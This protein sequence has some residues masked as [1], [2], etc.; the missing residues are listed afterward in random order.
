[1]SRS[2]KQAEDVLERFVRDLDVGVVAFQI[3]H[4][5]QAAIEIRDLT[6]QIRQLR[7]AVG[8]RLA[9][10]LVKQTQQEQPI[11]TQEIAL[12]LFLPHAFEA[13]AKIIAVAVEEAALLDEVDEHHPVQH[14]RG[15]PFP[16]GEVLDAFDKAQEGVMLLLETVVESLGDLLYVEGRARPADHID[17]GGVCLFIQR[18]DQVFQSLDQRFARLAAMIDV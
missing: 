12:S 4:V 9:Q 11:E 6:K 18:D 10:A 15:I 16:V 2:K 13:I 17:Q 8:L 7:G 1:M 5:E 14:Q 3:V